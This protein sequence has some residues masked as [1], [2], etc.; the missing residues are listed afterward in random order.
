MSIFKDS[1]I[2]LKIQ[3]SSDKNFIYTI[4]SLKF[5]KIIAVKKVSKKEK[6][7]DLWFQINYEIKTWDKINKVSNIKIIN[8]FNTINKNFSQINSYLNMLYLILKNTAF[9]VENK[10]IFEI[11]N[12]I[13]KYTNPDIETKLILT[14]LKI[15][16]VLWEL[17][18]NHKNPTISK[19]LSFINKNKFSKIIKLTWINQEIKK[20]LQNKIPLN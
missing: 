2:I 5:W 1:W 17:D 13:N 4:F 3:K 12:L 20:E 14:Q 18:V 10:E 6:N 19:I 7:L 11:I 9:W 8:E 15:K 16:N